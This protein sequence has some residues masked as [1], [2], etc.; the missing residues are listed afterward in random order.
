MAVY[1][2]YHL[3][4]NEKPQYVKKKENTDCLVRKKNKKKT[5]NKN[6]KGVALENKV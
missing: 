1:D 5:D 3:K 2:K 6:R 4:T